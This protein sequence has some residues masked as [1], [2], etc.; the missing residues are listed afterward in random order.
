MSRPGGLAA[1]LL[2]WLGVFAIATGI[3]A[4]Y[5]ARTRDAVEAL[6]DA[7]EDL[8]AKV[9]ARECPVCACES[10]VLPAEVEP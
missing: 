8:A 7:V 5:H 9:E 1:D 2:I 3:S 10:V 4:S 6:A